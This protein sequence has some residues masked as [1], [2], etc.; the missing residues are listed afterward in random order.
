GEISRK[1]RLFKLEV[2]G[3]P[4]LSDAQ[5]SQLMY[6]VSRSVYPC[7]LLVEHASWLVETT[8]E[9]Q[10]E[11]TPFRPK[12]EPECF[13]VALKLCQDAQDLPRVNTARLLYN[14]VI[15]ISAQL[16]DL[17]T[18]L[19][20][21]DGFR[22][23]NVERPERRDRREFAEKVLAPK[24]P[25]FATC[26]SKQA[27]FLDTVSATTDGLSLRAL[28]AIGD[29]AQDE[30]YGI[31]DVGQ[32][33]SVYKFG[34]KSSPWRDPDLAEKIRDN[35]CFRALRQSVFGQDAALKEAARCVNKAVFG[36]SALGA[37]S[38]PNRPR[39]VLFLA[40]PTGTGKT[41][42]AKQLAKFVF[43]SPDAFTRF[44][45]SEY[46]ASHS[47]TRL[48][49]APPSYVGYDSGGQLTNAVRDK[50]FSLLLFDEIE[51]AHPQILDKFLQILDEGRLTD[52][53][54][55]TVF[56][57]ETLIVFTSNL[58]VV[59][60]DERGNPVFRNNEPVFSVLPDQDPSVV[61]ET[62]RR[63]VEKHFI[64]IARPELYGRL[65]KG[66]VV[67]NFITADAAC[68]IVNKALASFERQ[69]AQARPGAV[70]SLDQ[71]AREA[72]DS[73]A[74]APDSP[75]RPSLRRYGGR[76]I[77]DMVES[78][79]MDPAIEALAEAGIAETPRILGRLTTQPNPGD[80][81]SLSFAVEQG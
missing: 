73:Y 24:F 2:N 57:S 29:L 69:L 16:H 20:G 12:A 37:E 3:S 67:L 13:R 75:D 45:M 28:Q 32:A 26:A 17:P 9:P 46:S 58:G 7:A 21:L 25:D 14:P 79:V 36:F 38:S 50:P 47:D 64:T 60:M 4:R 76:R 33:I 31:A 22:H 43:G 34:V 70:L 62:I 1:R 11:N 54:G 35:G 10:S 78:L 80:A 27:E 55:A 63:G 6:A 8:P 40:G 71:A 53:K 30:R 51:K 56:F 52:S 49:G 61:A 15:W 42:L 77:Q 59:E 48:I 41:E 18:W 5:L 66:I 19:T 72:L 44:D 68:Q 65:A 23:I 74:S 39:G 81:P